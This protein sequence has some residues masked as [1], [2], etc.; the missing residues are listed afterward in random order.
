MPAATPPEHFHHRVK[1][2]HITIPRWHQHPHRTKPEPEHT[3]FLQDLLAAGQ[4]HHIVVWGYSVNPYQLYLVDGLRRLHAAREVGIPDI[5]VDI[6]THYPDERAAWRDAI[7]R[8]TTPDH[9]TITRAEAAL[10]L[11]DHELDPDK[12]YRRYRNPYSNALAATADLIRAATRTPDPALDPIAAAFGNGLTAAD[13]PA[14]LEPI[15]QLAHSPY[16]TVRSFAANA[17]P[18][19]EAAQHTRGLQ[20]TGQLPP[21]HASAISRVRDLNLQAKLADTALERGLSARELRRY[22]Q[23]ANQHHNLDV[24]DRALASDR[25]IA[26]D[27]SQQLTN[28]DQLPATTRRQASRALRD[29]H[30]A[31]QA[32]GAPRP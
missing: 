29:L 23:H 19:I 3:A 14:A 20:R 5:D 32:G 9:P 2:R 10:R 31:L 16:P 7:L 26:R 22:T 11:I 25:A 12:N 6:Y 4:A 13:L 28:Y 17:L 21:S 27:L 8:N 15:L 30:A 24:P 18:L 1:L